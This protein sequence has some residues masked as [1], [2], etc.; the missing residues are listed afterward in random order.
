M[1][2]NVHILATC[3]NPALIDTTLLVFKTLRTG[4]PSANVVVWNNGMGTA[5]SKALVTESEKRDCK[6][7]YVEPMRHD[8]WVFEVMRRSVEPFW[9]LDTDIV[10]WDSI[11]QFE[12]DAEF[13]IAGRFEPAFREPW[14]STIKPSRL[15]TSLLWINPAAIQKLTREW[16]GRWHPKGFPFV[17]EVEMIKQHYV[18]QGEGKAPLFYDT[19]CG[20]YQAI[21]GRRFSDRENACFEHLHCGVYSDRIENA[22]PGIGQV[23]RTI[24]NDL[25]A[26]KGL[27]EQQSNFYKENAILQ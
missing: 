22:L 16:M 11:E 17:P 25:N 5:Q 3:L 2:I 10:F 18:P 21:G 20:L 19:C 27:Q 15:H 4:F 24:C 23:H 1:K 8:N 14:T 26:A 7:A 6:C 9:I 13:G 12:Q